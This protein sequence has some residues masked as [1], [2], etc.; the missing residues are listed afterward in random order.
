MGEASQKKA[1]DMVL[2]SA[3]VKKLRRWTD[4]STLL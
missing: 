4:F 1:L 3:G 2:K